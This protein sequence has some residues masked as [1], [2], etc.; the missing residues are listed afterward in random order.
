MS[1]KGAEALETYDE[2][3][4]KNEREAMQFGELIAP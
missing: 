1:S 3:S 2:D 4:C